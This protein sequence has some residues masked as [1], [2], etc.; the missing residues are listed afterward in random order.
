MIEHFSAKG[1]ALLRALQGKRSGTWLDAILN[2]RKLAGSSGL[3]AWQ[4]PS[5]WA[6]YCVVIASLGQELWTWD[7]SGPERV[8]FHYL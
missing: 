3:S 6:Y 7:I 2:A 4:L 5:D 1:A 8:S